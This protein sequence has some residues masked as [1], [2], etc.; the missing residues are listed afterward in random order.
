MVGSWIQIKA[1]GPYLHGIYL[2]VES[3]FVLAKN[4][5]PCAETQRNIH[6]NDKPCRTANDE[7][8]IHVVKLEEAVSSL[9]STTRLSLVC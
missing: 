9:T 8:A 6:L 7:V 4:M 5:K 2:F 3:I 1:W